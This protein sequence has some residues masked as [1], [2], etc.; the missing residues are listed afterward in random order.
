MP[1]RLAHDLRLGLN[2]LYFGGARR[3]G[4]RGIY[5]AVTPYYPVHLLQTAVDGRRKITFRGHVSS[6]DSK[7]LQCCGTQGIPLEEVDSHKLPHDIA[8]VDGVLHALRK[9]VESVLLQVH[10]SMISTSTGGW[11]RSL[12]G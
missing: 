3:V 11:F 9:A 1:Q 10:P 2:E 8:V 5:D 4:Q 6:V 7:T 12:V